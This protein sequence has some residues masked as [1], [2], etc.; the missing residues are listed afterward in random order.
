LFFTFEGCTVTPNVF[1]R[2]LALDRLVCGILKYTYIIND[3]SWWNSGHVHGAEGRV[4]VLGTSSETAA[5]FDSE[6][7]TRSQLKHPHL[8]RV[9]RD[10]SA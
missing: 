6:T 7:G 2:F 5:K 8:M 10:F 1:A 4:F 9:H 3:A